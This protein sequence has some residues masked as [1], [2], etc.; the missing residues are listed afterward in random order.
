M[1]PGFRDDCV[2]WFRVMVPDRPAYVIEV[3]ARG[4]VRFARADM[5]RSH[6]SARLT[7]GNYTLGT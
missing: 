6:W 5:V 4:G 7:I 1:T 3:G 2:Y